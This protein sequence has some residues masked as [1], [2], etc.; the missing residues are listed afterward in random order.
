MSNPSKG[1]T[2]RLIIP[3]DMSNSVLASLGPTSKVE[4][5]DTILS[6]GKMTTDQIA[7]IIKES[8]RLKDELLHTLRQLGLARNPR[9]AATRTRD[10]PTT[11]SEARNELD[12]KRAQYQ[13]LQ[14]GIETLEREIEETKKQANR[15]SEVEQAGFASTEISFSKG[16]YNR[17]LGRIP[18]RKVPD[19]QRSLQKALGDQ[20][21][22]APGSRVKDWIYIL[23]A[24]P[25][26]KMSLATQTLILYDFAQTEIPKPEQPDLK[27]AKETLENRIREQSAKLEEAR[28]EM[29]RFQNEAGE[30]LNQLAD[31]IQDSL[32]QLQAVLR[33]GE[34]SKASQAFAWLAKAPTPKMLN[35]LSTNGVLFET[36]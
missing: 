17:I 9:A 26:E 2:L 23:V 12:Q 14:S 10:Y 15:I 18:A 21:I 22:L 1:T 32:I 6:A 5:S 27:T 11:L 4:S 28:T 13:D 31:R 35:S 7:T 34:G 3:K 30:N 20:V 29:K 24:A 19:A 16:E 8:T 25:E 33:I 36:E